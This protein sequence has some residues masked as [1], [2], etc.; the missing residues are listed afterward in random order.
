MS[1]SEKYDALATEFSTREYGD[2]ER[3]YRRR[4]G[5]IVG[6]GPRLEPGDRILDIACGDGGQAV[7]LLEHGLEYTGIDVSP[8]MVAVARER[9]GERAHVEVGDMFTYVPARPVAATTCFRAVY[10]ATDMR[11]LFEHLGSYTER[12]LV[13]DFSPRDFDRGRM[14]ADLRTAGFGRVDLQ[15]FFYPQHYAPPRPVERALA[16][17]QRLPVVA[18]LVLRVRFTYVVAAYRV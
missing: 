17:A 8:Q 18:P 12:K 9:L 15:P 13:F 3:Y 7:P 1:I 2:P 14:V 16:L 6:V 4:A 5:L 11:A 10:Y